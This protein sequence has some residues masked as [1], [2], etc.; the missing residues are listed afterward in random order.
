MKLLLFGGTFDPPHNGHRNNLEAAIRLV[1]PDKVLVMPAGVPP[2][3][4][5]SSTPGDLRLK[6][7]ECFTDLGPFVE[8]SDWEIRQAEKGAKSYTI[9]TLEMLQNTYPGAELYMSVGSDMLLTFAGGWYRW[10]DMLQMT[11]LV[12]QSRQDGDMT[13]LRQAA[14]PLEDQGGRILFAQA[15]ALPCASSDIRSGK[16]TPEQLEMLL[17]EKV[18]R[19]IAEEKLY[20]GC[21]DTAMTYEQAK[22]MVKKRLSEKRYK[23]TI[24][25]KKMAVKLAKK[26][27]ADQNKAAMAAILH[28]A[29]KEIPKSEMLQIFAKNAIMAENAAERPS[30]V[31]HGIAAA[32]LAKTEWGIE[33]AEILSAIRCHTT[34]KAKM[35]LLDKIIYMADMTCAERDF[36]GVEELRELEMKDLDA[37]LLLAFRQTIRF[38][39]EGNG[40]MDPETVAAYEDLR[41]RMAAQKNQKGEQQ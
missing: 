15:E 27:G 8:L 26:Y 4:H 1:Q 41:D 34:G 40:R 32:I 39:E 21:K 28:D 23:H 31:W 20:Q 10:Q 16:Y 19:I 37:A 14:K 2:H 9:H 3:K 13:A 29:A 35:S 30:P 33:D 11:T 36:P 24:N 12:V 17:P 5:A 6:M 25:V 38:V 7:C 18:R 22:K